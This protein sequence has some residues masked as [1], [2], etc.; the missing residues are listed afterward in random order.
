[1]TWVVVPC[2]KYL[3][4]TTNGYRVQRTLRANDNRCSGFEMA[5]AHLSKELCEKVA[6]LLNEH[7]VVQ[8]CTPID[9]GPLES[10]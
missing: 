10:P 5:F 3:S 9:L 7:E 6:S 8:S 2:V 4:A 1:M